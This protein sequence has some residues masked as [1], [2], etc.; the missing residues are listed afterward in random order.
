[1][2][3]PVTTV[4]S[5]VSSAA[6]T[7]NCEYRACAN[8][9]RGHGHG[10]E[11]FRGI[12]D[13]GRVSRRVAPAPTRSR[14]GDRRATGVRPCGAPLPRTSR[15]ASPAG[16]GRSAG[17]PAAARRPATTA[18]A[19]GQSRSM[20]PSSSAENS[21]CTRARN[22]HDLVVIERL[23]QHAGRR[24]RDAG[25]PEHLDAHVA[26]RRS[27]PAPWTCRRHRRQSSAGIGFPPA[28][29]SSDR[30]APRR[31]RAPAATRSPARR[32]PLSH[33]SRGE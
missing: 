12:A 14:R 27:P 5:A 25:D 10:N 16:P 29:R 31:R 19:D 6:P 32:H 20:I 30:A 15:P 33:A 21:P 13:V 24:V 17:P 26:R 1:M 4:P 8:C 23:R 3:Q 9:A 22:R 28:S 11:P 2:L 7:L 18:S